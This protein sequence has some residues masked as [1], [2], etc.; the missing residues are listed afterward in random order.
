MVIEM[1]KKRVVKDKETRI[2]FA[3]LAITSLVLLPTSHNPKII[4][5]HVELIREL[6]EFLDFPWGRA[7][8]NLLVSNLIKKDEI[9]LSQDSVAI[10]GYVD[11]IQLVM[12]AAVP[13]LK[14][15]VSTAEPVPVVDYDSQGDTNLEDG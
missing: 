11:A 5:E 14:E 7:S 13:K 8:F 6:Q 3:C 15:E 2:K 12:I 1:L 4:S 10:Q 9:A